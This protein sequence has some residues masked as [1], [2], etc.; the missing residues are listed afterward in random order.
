MTSE[1]A[2]KNISLLLASNPATPDNDMMKSIL[3]RTD[4]NYPLEKP[5]K[6]P[7]YISLVEENT[8]PVSQEPEEASA[9]YTAMSNSRDSRCYNQSKPD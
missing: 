5:K 4:K 1:K 3:Q 8:I 2:Q 6:L 9:L 7:L